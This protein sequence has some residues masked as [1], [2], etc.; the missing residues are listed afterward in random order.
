[1]KMCPRNM[2]V[3]ICRVPGRPRMRV[4][5]NFKREAVIIPMFWFIATVS[6]LLGLAISFT[7]VWFLHQTSPTTYSLIGSLNKIH[8]FIADILLFKVPVSV[9]NLFNILLGLCRMSGSEEP[10]MADRIIGMR[11]ALREN[12]EKLGSPL[13]WEHVTN[14]IGMFCYLSMTLNKSI[15]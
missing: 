2:S 1:M 5:A 12:L 4:V 15:D 6:D 3:L 8:L 14:Q 13:S 9:P 10:S 11:T 7:S